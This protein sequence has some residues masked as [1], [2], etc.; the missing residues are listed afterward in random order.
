MLSFIYRASTNIAAILNV[1]CS[2]AQ[3][4]AAKARA[5]TGIINTHDSFYSGLIGAKAERPASQT[6]TRGT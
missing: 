1:A 3:S 6:N 4:A 2:G 5:S